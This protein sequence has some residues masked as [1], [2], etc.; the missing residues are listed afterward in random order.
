MGDV[1]QHQFQYPKVTPVQG[2]QTAAKPQ[3]APS[4]TA[5]TAGAGSGR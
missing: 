5:A 4:P 2:V 1:M 3:G